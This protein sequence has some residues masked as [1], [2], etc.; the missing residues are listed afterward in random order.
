MTSAVHGDGVPAHGVPARALRTRLGPLAGGR[1]PA[2][3]VPLLGASVAE[4]E[5]EAR[6]AVAAGADALEWRIDAFP[7]VAVP[8]AAAAALGQL[9]ASLAGVPLIA[10]LRSAREGGRDRGLDD[11]QALAIVEAI[12]GCGMADFVDVEIAA[13][14]AAVAAVRAAAGQAGTQLIGSSHDF[15]G[16]PPEPEILARFRRAAELGV[17][18]AKVAVMPAGARDVLALLSATE[19]ASRE[20]AIPLISMAMGQAGL[21]SRVFGATFGSALTFAAGRQASAP[22]QLPAA[23]LVRILD[24]VGRRG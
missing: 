8:G 23:E 16:T 17:D 7:D 9:R 12:A 22:G 6:E 20:L 5:A 1:L 19:T 2:V 15:A 24:R 4:L 18:V 10:T 3:C 11:R 13:G 21:V 14:E